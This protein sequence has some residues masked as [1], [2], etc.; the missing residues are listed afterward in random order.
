MEKN[1]LL[2]KVNEYCSEKSYTEATLTSSFKDKFVDH[3]I[4]KYPEGDINDENVLNDMKFALNTAFSGASAIITEK[5]KGFDTKE[6]EYK[7]QIAELNR[8]LNA[9]RKGDDD[10]DDTKKT[11]QIPKEL[12]DKIDELEKYKIAESKKEKYKNIVQLAKKGIRQDLH[13]SFD[14]FVETYDASLDV[15]EQKQADNLIA[16]FQ[17]IFKDSIGDIKPLAPQQTQKR[18]EEYLA[19]I[20]KVKIQ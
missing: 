15:D 7:G 19:S 2:Q 12:Q 3:F 17:A 13:K 18:E 8:Q 11:I 5:Q 10:D 14:T 20:P 16:R 6:N 9:L 4:K 1:D